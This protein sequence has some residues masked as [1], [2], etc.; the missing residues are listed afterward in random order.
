MCFHIGDLGRLHATAGQR[1]PDNCLL[2]HAVWCCQPAAMAVLVAG[3]AANDCQDWV[4]GGERIGQSLQH[5]N[6]AT[7]TTDKTV[8]RGI[9]S[10]ATAVGGHHVR[11]R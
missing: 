3:P 10:L 7:F 6:A 2:R 11:L 5:D 9:K 1:L 4:M 8:R